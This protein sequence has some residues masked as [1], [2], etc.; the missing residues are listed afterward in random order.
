MSGHIPG[1]TPPPGANVVQH[2][3]NEHAEHEWLR[4][5]NDRVEFAITM[6]ALD[7][8]LPPLPLRVLDIG[9]GPGRYA[10]ELAR[11]GYD[12]TL[13]DFAATELAIARTRADEANVPLQIVECDARD[14]SQFADTSRSDG[15]GFDAVLMMGPLYHLLDAADRAKAIAEAMRVLVPGGRFFAAYI[16][17][18]AVLRFWAKYDPARVANDRPRYEEHLRTG[19]V[20]DNF[21]F[22]DVYLAHPAEITPAMEA[23]G[24]AT[25]DLIGCEGVISMIR[26][27]VNELQGDAWETWIDL[28]YA[29]AKDPS[30][31]GGA[32]HLLY[33][34]E[35]PR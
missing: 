19:E 34:G 18:T 30:N 27:K 33:V 9:G 31:H 23:A 3:Y 14:L 35:S 32:E 2:Y 10:I 24:F 15:K 26:E 17:R 16:T 28:N 6:R 20:R 13:A 1:S 11:R 22:T 5:K 29:L 4:L 12:V 7:E 8:Y 21:G 25:L